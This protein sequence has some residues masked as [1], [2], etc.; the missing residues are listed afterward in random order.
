MVMVFAMAKDDPQ[1]EFIER[2]ELRDIMR[3]MGI[4]H[5]R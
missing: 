5:P 2:P 4:V 3:R 1:I